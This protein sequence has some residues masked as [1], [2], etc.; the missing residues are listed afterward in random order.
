MTRPTRNR[1]SLVLFAIGAMALAYMA[2]TW[3]INSLAVVGAILIGLSI[4]VG[5]S[6]FAGRQALK[7]K[8]YELATHRLIDFERELLASPWKQKV[9]WLFTGMHTSSGLALA[10]STLGAVRLEEGKMDE[11][12][13]HF[14]RALEFDAAYSFPYANLALVAK[15]RNDETKVNEFRNEAVRLGLKA[16]AVDALL[17]RE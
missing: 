14:K 15:K 12:V 2:P 13:V 3:L 7:E 16:S 6:F 5:K 9:A 1:V 10:R 11:A 4:F 17:I 8:K